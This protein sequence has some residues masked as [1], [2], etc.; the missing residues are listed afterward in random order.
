MKFIITLPDCDYYL[1]QML[2]QINNFRKFGYEENTIYL[3]GKFNSQKSEN[4]QKILKSGLIKS[5]VIVFNDERIKPKYS[6]SLRP[7]LMKKYIEKY[8]KENE[9][10]FYTDP[11]VLFIKKMN[12]NKYLKNRVW[13]MSNTSSYL[14]SNYI[15]SKGEELFDLM[16]QSVGIDKSIVENNDINAGGAQ[17]ILKNTTYEYWNKVEK[18]SEKLYEL[19]INTAHRFTPNAPIQAWT[20]EMWATLWNAW[21]FKYKTKIDNE[22]DFSWATDSIEKWDGTNI[23]HNAGA[24]IDNGDYFLKTKYQTSP[25]NKKISV[26]DKY[27]SFNYLKEINETEITFN[28][29]LF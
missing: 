23:Y 2:V 29:I 19:M 28:K 9:L 26:S 15:K 13:Y 20:A 14:N 3:I 7:F 4:L 10:Y 18:D 12:F 16:C 11:D 8:N 1:W 17:I 6:P 24:V 27:C 22:L 21:L 5:E 25:F